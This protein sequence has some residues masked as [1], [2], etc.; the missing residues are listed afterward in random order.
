VD[1]ATEHRCRVEAALET[2][3]LDGTGGPVDDD[4]A[5]GVFGRDYDPPIV[6]GDAFDCPTLRVR[7]VCD[8]A[9]DLGF[10]M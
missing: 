3:D 5:A 6:G 4:E 8:W 1:P 2:S 9:V 7:Q 10:T